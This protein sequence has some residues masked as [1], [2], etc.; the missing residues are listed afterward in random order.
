MPFRILLRDSAGRERVERADI[1]L[2]CTGKYGNPNTLGDG[3]I[4]APGEMALSGRIHRRIPDL[5]SG[6]ERWWGKTVLLVKIGEYK[7]ALAGEISIAPGS[8]GNI[9]GIPPKTIAVS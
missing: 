2:D 8:L 9:S 7:P 3:G 1:V 4:P 6:A 5:R